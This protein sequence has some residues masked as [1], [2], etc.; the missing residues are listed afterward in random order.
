MPQAVNF[1]IPTNKAIPLPCCSFLVVPSGFLKSC[2]LSKHLPSHV[3]SKC[4]LSKCCP[5][6]AVPV[7]NQHKTPGLT[8]LHVSQAFASLW[9]AWPCIVCLNKWTLTLQVKPR[10]HSLWERRSVRFFRHID[11]GH[12]VLTHLCVRQ[13]LVNCFWAWLSFGLQRKIWQ[14]KNR[15]ESPPPWNINCDVF[16][17]DL[18]FQSL[19][20]LSIYWWWC[21]L[22]CHLFSLLTVLPIWWRSLEVLAQCL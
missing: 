22:S 16:H 6:S 14:G 3:S 8:H 15:S 10:F 7:W 1:F 2:F 4:F 11:I 21:Y 9:G 20:H 17:P 19:R 18:S 12:K 13:I 5:V